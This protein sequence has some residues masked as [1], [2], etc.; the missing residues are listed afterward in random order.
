MIIKKQKKTIVYVCNNLG[1]FFSHRENIVQKLKSLNYKIFL[2]HGNAGSKTIDH[3]YFKKLKKYKIK[4]YKIPMHSDIKNVFYDVVSFFLIFKII[5]KIKPDLIHTI[6]PKANLYGGLVSLFFSKSKLIMSVSGLGTIFN[7]NYKFLKFIFLF[8]HQIIFL[9]KNFNIIFHNQNDLEFY[10]KKFKI[11]KNK[12][13]KT[14]GSG[15]DLKKFNV[16]KKIRNKNILFC[17]RVLRSKGII[18]FIKAAEILEKK[19]KSWQ[20]LIAGTIDYKNPDSVDY[21]FL[22]QKTQLKNI[23]FIGY[24]QN[25]KKL[26]ENCEIYCLPSY[27]EGLSKTLLEAASM[28]LP[29]IVSNI[30][31]NTQ[32]VMKNKTG[33]IFKTSNV[34]DLVKKIYY[35]ASNKKIRHEYG[36][37]NRKLALKHFGIKKV[38]NLH[39]QIYEK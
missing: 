23:K 20:F 18:D 30:P 7:G 12:L 16:I 25:V 32:V 38:N 17:G 31:G 28:S 11:D 26:Y 22:R 9:K 14:F 8:L 1:Y 27:S 33:L 36:K 5:K 3:Q 39:L 4:A 6:S 13:Y 21:K 35:L 34:N 29:V 15:V 2:V 10:K 24:H 37:N 19:L